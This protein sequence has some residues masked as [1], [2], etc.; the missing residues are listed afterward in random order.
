MTFYHGTDAVSGALIEIYGLKVGSYLTTSERW[1]VRAAERRALE[2]DCGGVVFRVAARSG[3][4]RLTN[5]GEAQ[6]SVR[7]EVRRVRYVGRERGVDFTKEVA[8]RSRY[9]MKLRD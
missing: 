9:S 8:D 3:E 1:A 7:L 5:V 2:A 4:F 6:A